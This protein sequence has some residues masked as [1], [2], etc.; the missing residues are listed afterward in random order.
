MDFVS[1]GHELE[2]WYTKLLRYSIGYTRL[3]VQ[4]WALD[5]NNLRAKTILLFM[6]YTAEG[7]PTK[8]RPLK[9][10]CYL[11]GQPALVHFSISFIFN[12]TIAGLKAGTN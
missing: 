6:I 4:F 1:L 3:D 5:K 8:S 2:P 11:Q 10:T 7:D 12:R 9:L